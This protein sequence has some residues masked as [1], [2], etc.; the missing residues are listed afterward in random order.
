MKYESNKIA[1]IICNPP[2]PSKNTFLRQAYFHSKQVCF[3]RLK[4]EEE[5]EEEEEEDDDDFD[6]GLWLSGKGVGEQNRHSMYVCLR[7]SGLKQ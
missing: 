2:M 7:T 4:E 3:C 6:V 1:T 5:E